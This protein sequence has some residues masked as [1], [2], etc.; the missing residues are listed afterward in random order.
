MGGKK[1]DQGKSGDS[2][3]CAF[4]LAINSRLKD[5]KHS[6]VQM[7]AF[8]LS[9]IEPII[10]NKE[11]KKRLAVF[12]KIKNNV[13]ASKWPCM[14]P[15]CEL[16]AIQSHLLQQRGILDH[17][18]E[19]G[20]LIQVKP[21]D[22]FEIDTKGFVQ[23]KRV[24]IREVIT[25]PL[26]C[27]RHDSSIFSS[28]ES[29]SP[30]FDSHQAQLLFSYRALCAELRK[31]ERN[32][33]L[34]ER[35]SRARTLESYYSPAFYKL[36][37]QGMALDQQRIR[38]LRVFKEAFEQELDDPHGQFTFYT[39]HYP[40]VKVSV[41]AIFSMEMEFS[42]APPSLARPLDSVFINVIPKSTHLVVIIGYHNSYTNSRIRQYA[43]DWRKHEYVDITPFLSDLVTRVET[44][45]MAESLYLKIPKQVERDYLNYFTLT[46][47]E[48]GHPGLFPHNLFSLS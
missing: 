19:A 35:L 34:H 30:D 38:D 6:P 13:F 47:R 11:Q 36:L 22:L 8:T 32:T 24:G 33:R 14:H 46:I 7:S 3:N 31:N 43:E 21:G 10:M 26:F 16:P 9:L 23:F 18:T 48:N 44:W 15:D 45:A 28:I 29:Q 12:Q 20:H 1:A 25:Y 40:P 4:K 2:S 41:S 5:S 39:C 27:N 37:E 42:I 17:L